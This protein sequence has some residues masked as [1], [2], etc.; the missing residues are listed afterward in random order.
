MLQNQY[1]SR[2]FFFNSIPESPWLNSIA[3]IKGIVIMVA[4]LLYVYLQGIGVYT[5]KV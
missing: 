5:I 2:Q 4:L 1:L 3:F